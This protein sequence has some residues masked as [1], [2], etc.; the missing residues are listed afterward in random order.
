M[1]WEKSETVGK[2]LKQF[3]ISWPNSFQLTLSG[4][5]VGHLCVVRRI[6]GRGC[7]QNLQI[8]FRFTESL[9]SQ[10][11][12]I[13][14]LAI[15]ITTCMA[16]FCATICGNPDASRSWSKNDTRDETFLVKTTLWTQHTEMNENMIYIWPQPLP[17]ISHEIDGNYE[18][19]TILAVRLVLFI[20]VKCG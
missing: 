19:H 7:K 10:S 3:L 9:K 13:F 4:W 20:F 2:F 1:A 14:P 17:M 8:L 6:Y 16:I 15:V 5:C 18:T 12:M 11:F